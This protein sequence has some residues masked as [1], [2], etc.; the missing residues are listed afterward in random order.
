MFSVSGFSI[1]YTVRKALPINKAVFAKTLLEMKDEILGKGEKYEL[2]VAVVGTKRIRTI[3]KKYRN[4]DKPTDIL[5]FPISKNVGQI[6]INPEYSKRE[7]GK[8]DRQFANFLY[9]LF[10][11][12]CVHLRGHDHSPKMDKLE[13]NYRKHFKI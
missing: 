10:I 4:I 12:G 13:E 9:F 3:N 8:F 5:S 7:A 11:H 6:F 1:T 2:S